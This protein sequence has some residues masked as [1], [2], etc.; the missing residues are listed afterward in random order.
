MTCRKPAESVQIPAE[1]CKITK[2]S[3]K[4]RNPRIP[5]LGAGILG[6][7]KERLLS[8]LTGSAQVLS[9]YHFCTSDVQL[10][11][12]PDEPGSLSSYL[13]YSTTGKPSPA[14]VT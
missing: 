10:G 4:D 6:I 14:Q 7:K 13:H 9:W 5:K 11:G 2:T 12:I 1:T 8:A 3:S